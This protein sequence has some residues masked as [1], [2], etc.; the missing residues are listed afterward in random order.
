MT[1]PTS[2]EAIAALL[3]IEACMDRSSDD[4]RHEQMKDLLLRG[5]NMIKALAARLAEL[6]AENAALRLETGRLQS[7]AM[8]AVDAARSAEAE[9]DTALAQVAVVYDVEAVACAIYSARGSAPYAWSDM[10]NGMKAPTREQAASVIRA[11]TPASSTAA[12]TAMIDR[13]RGE[14]IE[15]AIEIV[16]NEIPGS[17]YLSAKTKIITALRNAKGGA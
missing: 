3:S 8:G 14:A 11:L 7:K 2:P 6:E 5:A 1:T 9:R 4:P 13:A 17:V 15:A 16:E 10:T 12:L